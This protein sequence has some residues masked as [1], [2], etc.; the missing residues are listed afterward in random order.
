MLD[1]LV[2]LNA[3]RFIVGASPELKFR[4][5]DEAD[6]AHVVSELPTARKPWY[7]FSPD[8]VQ[9]A[10][11]LASNMRARDS[12]YFESYAT[13]VLITPVF[14]PVLSKGASKAKIVWHLSMLL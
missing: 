13:D 7:I 1:F 10:S 8:F 3:R 9:I 12:A 5:T 14:R 4:T 2:V 6:T 11:F